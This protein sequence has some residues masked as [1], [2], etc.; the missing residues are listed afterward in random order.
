MRTFILVYFSLIIFALTSC[1]PSGK[2]AIV[3]G[4]NTC[5]TDPITCSGT[6]AVPGQANQNN[7]GGG[8]GYYPY[9]GGSGYYPYGGGT[10]YGY[11]QPFNYYNNTAYLC[12]CPTGTVPTY[13]A[14]G[15]LSCMSVNYLGSKTGLSAYFYLSWG[16]N[17]WNPMAQ[18]YRYNYGGGLNSCYNG[19]VQSCTVNQ[20]NT[21]PSGY[22]CRPNSNTSSLGLC[23]GS[24]R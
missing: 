24:Y 20:A 16:S 8:T 6:Q 5:V 1:Q 7:N 12:N 14:G 15:G 22:F 19:A 23:V 4:N 21:C 10:G 11:N 13:S 2:E 18:M 17:Q 3:S 9:G